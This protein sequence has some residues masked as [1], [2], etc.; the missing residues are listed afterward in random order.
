MHKYTYEQ[1]KQKIEN[2]RRFGNLPGAEVTERMLA[3]LGE[4]QTGLPYIHV[5]GTNGKGSTCAFL[6]SILSE[7]GLKV[8]L[9]TSPHLTEFEER[10]VVGKQMIPKEDVERLGNLLLSINFGV[11]PTM[12]DYCLLMAVL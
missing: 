5:A 12:F 11:T 3:T 4:P 7:A 9:F 2:S 10:I 6:A 8:G 1:V